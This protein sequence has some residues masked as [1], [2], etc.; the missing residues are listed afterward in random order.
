M[1]SK[2]VG[3]K[4]GYVISEINIFF[5]KGQPFFPSDYKQEEK[6]FYLAK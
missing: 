6:Y 4:K 5:L 2:I 3:G 1:I